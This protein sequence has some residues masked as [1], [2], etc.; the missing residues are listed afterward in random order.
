M[1]FATPATAQGVPIETLIPSAELVL[2]DEGIHTER[3]SEPASIPAET[4]TPQK[5]STSPIASQPKIEFPATPLVIS[6]SDLFMAY[7][8]L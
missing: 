3:V 7:L 6:T 2:V 8:K 5:G 1:A 4:P